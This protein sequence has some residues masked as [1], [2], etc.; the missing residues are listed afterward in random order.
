MNSKNHLLVILLI[1][2]IIFSQTNN[3][4]VTIRVSSEY[5]TQSDIIFIVGSHEQFGMWQANKVPLNK[6]DNYWEGVFKFPINTS[7][8]FKFTK[9]SWETEALNEN[10]KIPGNHNLT[11]TQDTI[12]SFSIYFWND[13]TTKIQFEGQITGNVEYHKNM[14]Y[15]G[16][17]SR[18]IAVWLPPGYEEN[19]DHKYPVLYMHDGQN[20]FDPQISFTKI[21]W[22][23]DE[24]ADSLIR[25][26]L[27]RPMIVVGI[28]STKDR[29]VEYSPTK[30]GVSY[31]QFVVTKLKSFIDS[32]YRT[33][34]DRM[35]TAV[36]GSSSGGLVSFMLAWNYSNIFSKA[37]CFSPAFKYDNFDYTKVI[38]EYKGL[39]KDLTIYI[40]NGGIG[41]E[42]ELQPG[43][44]LMVNILQEKGFVLNK[45]LIVNIDSTAEHNEAAWAKHVPQMLKLLYGN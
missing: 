29:S 41:L 30:K 40:D 36:G 6:S 27:I 24:T 43:V 19:K 45:D 2:I 34:P 39:K 35:N 15:E 22:Q 20:L 17:E 37:A 28:F 8:E 38:K 1:P 23:I 18:D 42:K 26:E 5:V 12:L 31:M 9:G 11:V 10:R 16:L 4:T 14:Q 25:N 32:T 3:R 21:D 7:L 44:D 33:L 13:G